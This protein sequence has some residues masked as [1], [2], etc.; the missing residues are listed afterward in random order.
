[1]PN[2]ATLAS[3]LTTRGWLV[4]GGA[5][6]GGILFIYLFVHMV[7][8]PGYTLVVSGVDPA[9]TGKMT[10]ALSA[11][12]VSYKLENNGT[13]IAVQDNQTAEARVALAGAGMLGNSQPG[14]E[15]FDK[16]SLGESNFQQQVTYQRALQGQLEATINSVQGVSGAQVELVLPSAQNQLFGEGQSAAS[17]AVL[18]SGTSMLDQSSVRGIAQL[19]ASSVPGLQL[20]KVTITGA[21]GQ[22]LW[23]SG[24]GGSGGGGG[25][26][27]CRKP[28]SATTRRPPPACRRCS[29]RRS[30]P[31]RRRCSST[32]T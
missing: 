24:S 27:A 6:V 1:M 10:S 22:L 17:A 28:S 16:Q 11:H 32:R 30:A 15:L 3:R 12:G 19:V 5:A 31:A 26:R 18:L 23:P 7:S 20:S 2:V 29:P 4:L 21:S 25:A 8:A 14:F 9:Q 13:A